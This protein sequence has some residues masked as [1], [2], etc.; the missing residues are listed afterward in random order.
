M[1]EFYDPSHQQLQDEFQSRPLADRLREL[2][3]KPFLDE[4]AQ[5]FIKSRNNFYLT[6]VDAQGFPTVSHKGGDEG[7]VILET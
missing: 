6:T 5:T 2:I 7:F 3:V 4:E 1:S